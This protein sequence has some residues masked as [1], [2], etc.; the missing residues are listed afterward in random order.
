MDTLVRQ[1]VA[2]AP[3]HPVLPG[4]EKYDLRAL[5]FDWSGEGEAFL[6]IELSSHEDYATLRFEGVS[7]FH[8]DSGDIRTAI[9]LMIQDTSRCPSASHHIPAVR[10]GGVANHGLSFWAQSVRRIANAA[11]G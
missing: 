10:V 9:V 4:A 1:Q 7:E 11:S 5:R 3:R 2:E 6:E 8:V